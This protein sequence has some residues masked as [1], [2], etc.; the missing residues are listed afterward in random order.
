MFGQWCVT[1]SSARKHLFGG[2]HTSTA[3]WTS[4]AFF[5]HGRI[6][7]W[8]AT[9]AISIAVSILAVSAK[10]GKLKRK[11]RLVPSTRLI[12]QFQTTQDLPIK[13]ISFQKATLSKSIECLR[14][15]KCV[16]KIFKLILQVF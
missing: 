3:T 6:L 8:Q 12:F 11:V 10:V 14:K 16:K 4:L 9:V 7:G 1:Y 2:I 13:C 5:G 15:K